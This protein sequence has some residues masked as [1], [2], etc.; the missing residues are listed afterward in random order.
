[1]LIG[2]LD[3]AASDANTSSAGTRWEEH[4]KFGLALAAY[5]ADHPGDEK[6]V[7]SAAE[8]RD[9]LGSFA[10]G[11]YDSPARFRPDD[12]RLKVILDTIRDR[13]TAP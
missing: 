7:R 3:E 10:P 13:T 2:L 11:P 4:V 8:L 6:L 5:N 9:L 12:P 1:M